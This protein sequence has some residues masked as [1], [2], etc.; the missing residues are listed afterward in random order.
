MKPEFQAAA[1]QLRSE[2]PADVLAVDDVEDANL[3][4]AMQREFD[5]TAYPTVVWIDHIRGR[6]QVWNDVRGIRTAAGLVRQV[7]AALR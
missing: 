7:R 4:P 3:K 5:V 6:H 1:R 2:F